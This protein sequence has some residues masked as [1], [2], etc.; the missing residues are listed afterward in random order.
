MVGSSSVGIDVLS[1]PKNSSTKRLRAIAEFLGHVDLIVVDERIVGGKKKLLFG[2]ADP[3]VKRS[4]IAPG[5]QQFAQP[6]LRRAY[7]ARHHD[8]PPIADAGS[9]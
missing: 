2:L 9:V 5:F 7:V 3:G 4:L 6:A 8:P 1:S